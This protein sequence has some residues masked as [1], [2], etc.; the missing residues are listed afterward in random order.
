M[1]YREEAYRWKGELEITLRIKQDARLPSTLTRVAGNTLQYYIGVG[2]MTGILAQ[3]EEAQAFY[4]LPVKQGED[5]MVI[6][7]DFSI[8]QEL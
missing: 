7:N 4:G 2:N 8:V 1:S 3:K 5:S 6:D